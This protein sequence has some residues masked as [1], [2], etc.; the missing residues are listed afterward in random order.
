M[1]W[2]EVYMFVGF[3][4]AAYSIVAN[5][6]IQTLGPFLSANEHR[7]WWLLWAYACAI[8][9]IVFIY[10]W[11]VN[12]GDVTYGRLAKFPEPATG[13]TW[14]HVIPPIF[15]LI[16]MKYGVPVS[17]TFLILT[18]FVPGNIGAVLQKSVLG[19]VLAIGVALVIYF[20][21]T[22]SVEKRFIDTKD[23][24][25]SRYWV[26]AQWIATGFLW[27]QW[28]IQDLANIFIYMPRHLSWQ[29]LLFAVVVLLTLH[30]VLFYF[31]GGSIQGIVTSK[32]NT[33]DVRSATI[34]NFLFGAMLLFFK[35]YSSMPM[36]T[37]FV[38]LGLLAGRELALTIHIHHREM[39]ET[40]K[41]VFKDI[42]KAGIGLAVSVALALTLPSVYQMVEGIDDS[43]VNV[44]VE[45]S[46]DKTATTA[47][48]PADHNRDLAQASEITAE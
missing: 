19:Y 24:P 45:R 4:L 43:D 8:L 20:I 44:A 21:V 26:I 37:T 16:L 22:R 25:I 35:E 48:D 6:A 28:L 30:A 13:F 47:Q 10:G 17:T 31:R 27:S 1:T 46:H 34:I 41:M 2:N 18:V 38:F 14:L 11:V 12:F 9:L 33:Q 15:I 32:T 5:D 23:Q 29:M 7:P 3:C 36:S 40:G 39:K 42:F